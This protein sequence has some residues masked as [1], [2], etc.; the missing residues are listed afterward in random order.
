M[1]NAVAEATWSETT[2]GRTGAI[3]AAVFV[4]AFVAASFGV[5]QVAPAGVLT[6]NSPEPLGGGS[7][8]G[9]NH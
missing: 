9:P 8:E 7:G 6:A 4:L 1:R 3:R 2:V 5:S